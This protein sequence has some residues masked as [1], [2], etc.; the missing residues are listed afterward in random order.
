MD[1]GGEPNGG[2]RGMARTSS[3]EVVWTGWQRRTADG[4]QGQNRGCEIDAARDRR[5]RRRKV[6]G[7][8]ATVNAWNQEPGKME[9]AKQAETP[10]WMRRRRS[11]ATAS[12][13]SQAAFPVGEWTGH[14][15]D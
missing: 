13:S 3:V 1:V 15:V 2:E 7:S 4:P 6:V 9:Q 12:G 10:W 11:V 5:T 8:R 14:G